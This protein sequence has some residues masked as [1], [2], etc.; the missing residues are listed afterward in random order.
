MTAIGSVNQETASLTQ[1]PQTLLRGSINL[2]RIE[3]LKLLDS[4]SDASMLRD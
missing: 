4:V 1:R 3:A 2:T